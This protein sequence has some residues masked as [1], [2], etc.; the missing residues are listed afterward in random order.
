MSNKPRE[1]GDLHWSLWLL[2]PAMLLLA[3]VA[4]SLLA[5]DLLPG[6][7]N[8]DGSFLEQ[9]TAVFLVKGEGS[10]FELLTVLFLAIAIIFCL[11]L[12]G[13]AL[14]FLSILSFVSL[15]Q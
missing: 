2:L 14:L 7:V 10:L 15:S 3:P 5:P 8:R 11:R 4:R 12:L 1:Y 6:N 13:P 9:V